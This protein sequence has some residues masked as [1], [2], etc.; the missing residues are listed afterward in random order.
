MVTYCRKCIEHRKPN[1]E[2]MIP[3]AVPETPWK[4][5]GT[6]LFSLNG[7]AYL[8]V[9]DYFSRFIEISILLVSQKSSET[10]RALKSI[11]TRHGIPNILR[12]DNG[13]KFVSTEFDELSNEHSFT[14]V[15]SSQKLPQAN[16]KAKR[17]VQTIKNALKKEKDPVKALMSYR[18]T[19]LE[20]G[21]GPAEMLF[22]R[23]IV[24]TVR[25]FPDQLKPSW[26]GLQKLRKHT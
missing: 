16:E 25:V 20:N 14:F 13:P 11:F 10:I 23:N 4:V 19:S 21:Y 15:T 24:I 9:I 18:A 7:Q 17:A 12:S 6:D 3:S 22:G 2:P 1:S 8:M 5:L 26:S